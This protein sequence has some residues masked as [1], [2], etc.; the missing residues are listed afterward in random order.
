M[1]DR[2]KASSD[3]FLGYAAIDIKS[4][5]QVKHIINRGIHSAKQVKMTDVKASS[6]STPSLSVS[7]PIQTRFKLILD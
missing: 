1:Y 6:Q 4:F 5:A 7:K 3:E 2:D